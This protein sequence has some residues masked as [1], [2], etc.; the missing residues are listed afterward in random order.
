MC[1][2]RL[3]LTA[4]GGVDRLIK[5]ERRDRRAL[6]AAIMHRQPGGVAHGDEQD[7]N[8]AAAIASIGVA[9]GRN[10][11]SECRKPLLTQIN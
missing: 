9:V 7:R 8:H 5:R 4:T 6:V 2:A 10:E 11:K 3:Q 1:P